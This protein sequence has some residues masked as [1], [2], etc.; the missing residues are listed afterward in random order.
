MSGIL[1]LESLLQRTR[2]TEVKEVLHHIAL[3]RKINTIEIDE[4]DVEFEEWEQ[5]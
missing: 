3:E 5:N 4:E 1:T 2:S